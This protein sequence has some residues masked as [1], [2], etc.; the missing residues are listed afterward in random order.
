MAATVVNS[1][2]AINVIVLVVRAFMRMRD[3]LAAIAEIAARLGEPTA[4]LRRALQ[5][6]HRPRAFGARGRVFAASL[7]RDK[8]NGLSL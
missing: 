7:G 5:K 6:K 8:S 4:W 2:H 1:R 3:A